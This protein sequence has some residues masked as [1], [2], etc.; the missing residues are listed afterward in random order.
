VPDL[1]QRP[2]LESCLIRPIRFCLTWIVRQSNIK[3]VKKE[4]TGTG[5]GS[6]SLITGINHRRG[7]WE[8]VEMNFASQ[9]KI[10][11]ILAFSVSLL[12]ASTNYVYA[13]SNCTAPNIPSFS[14]LKPASPVAP[15]C[16]NEVT[17]SHTCSEPVVL[18]YNS[19]VEN[20]NTQTKS[21]YSNVDRYISE[22]NAYLKSAREYAECEVNRL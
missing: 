9:R 13:G 15:D 14:E 6:Y 10:L 8:E 2:I 1:K 4:N 21:Y 22:L 17:K 3:I 7:L 11:I 18:Q 19:E 12:T 5:F 16:I 20:Y